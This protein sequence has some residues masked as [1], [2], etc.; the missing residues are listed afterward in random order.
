MTFLARTAPRTGIAD[1][2]MV[3]P[4]RA[5]GTLATAQR[6]AAAALRPSQLSLGRAGVGGVMVLSPR[7]LTSALGVAPATAVDTSWAVQMLGAREIAL[8]LGA[9]TALHRSDVRAARLWL[10]AG[11][12]CDAIDAVVVAAAVGRGRV[13]AAPGAVVVA[14]ATTAA[15]VQAAALAQT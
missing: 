4:T 8:G 13:S 5:T 3:P 7:T 9:Y 15:A 12:L 1:T 14:T 2:P 10:A 6:L 11:L